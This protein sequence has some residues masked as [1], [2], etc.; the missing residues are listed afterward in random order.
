MR[1]G[2]MPAR[3]APDDYRASALRGIFVKR[4]D[5]GFLIAR[6]VQLLILSPP[7]HNTKRQQAFGQKETIVVCGELFFRGRRERAH[8]VLRDIRKAGLIPF[9]G[10]R[11]KPHD[12]AVNNPATGKRVEVARLV[13]QKMIEIEVMAITP[14]PIRIV[15][16]RSVRGK[17]S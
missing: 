3:V 13:E 6:G 17:R 2:D 15:L 7:P 8:D 1:A 14:S 12:V 11:R 16:N 5:K 9:A 4:L 10:N